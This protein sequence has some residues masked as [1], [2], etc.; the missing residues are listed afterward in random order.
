MKPLRCLSLVLF[1]AG[2]AAAQPD[3]DNLYSAPKLPSGDVLERLNLKLAWSGFAP[4]EDR[5]DGI[6]SVQFAPVPREGKDRKSV[7]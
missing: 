4:T 7:V 5:R 1:L 2:A 3:K 6:L